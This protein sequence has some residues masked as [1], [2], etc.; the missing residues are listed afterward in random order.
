M[1]HLC[2]CAWCCRASGL[3][4]CPREGEGKCAELPRAGA[5]GGLLASLSPPLSR[6]TPESL[7]GNAH[8]RRGALGCEGHATAASFFARLPNARPCC[9][10][11]PRLCACWCVCV[12]D[13]CDVRQAPAAPSGERESGDG[14]EWKGALPAMTVA[15]VQ[16]LHTHINSTRR[17]LGDTCRGKARAARV[18]G[19]QRWRGNARRLAF[20][21][22]S[23]HPSRLRHPSPATYKV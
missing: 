16:R 4:S 9:F 21:E 15:A 14:E 10:M 18:R 12:C 6:P 20:P 7:R 8:M 22:P 2:L 5:R 17:R 19:E 11:K 3:V 23:A 1:R 13:V